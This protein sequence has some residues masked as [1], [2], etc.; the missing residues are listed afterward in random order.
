MVA[1]ARNMIASARNMKQKLNSV[2]L[3]FEKPFMG[4]IKRGLVTQ[5][6]E[7]LFLKSEKCINARIRHCPECRVVDM[8][9]QRVRHM[10]STTSCR[11]CKKCSFA[12]ERRLRGVD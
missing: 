11:C 5:V 4:F 2:F 6:L 9:F 3:D 10:I 8:L 1:G 7:T 12:G